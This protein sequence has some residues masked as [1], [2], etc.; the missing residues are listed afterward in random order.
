MSYQ[1]ACQTPAKDAEL[2]KAWLTYVASSEGQSAAGETAGSAPL[3]ADFGT[4]VQAAI[5]TIKAS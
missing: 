2:V 5:D 3:T 1:I 4:K